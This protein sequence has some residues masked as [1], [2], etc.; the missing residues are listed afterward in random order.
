MADLMPGWRTVK[1]GDVVRLS[2]Q[3]SADPLT[4]GIERYVGLEHIEP[5]ELRVRTW[6]NVG[7]GTTFTSRF[8]PGQVLFGKR[9]AYQRKVAVAEFEGVCS[10]DIYVLE[11]VNPELL[12]P[13]LLP[14]ICQT[15]AFFEH[16][17]GTS[18]GSLSPRTNWGSLADFGFALPPLDEQQA[19][20]RELA[21]IEAA[22]ADAID[23]VDAGKQFVEVLTWNLTT[24]KSVGGPRK[25]APDWTYAR[26]PGVETLPESWTVTRLTE[27]ARLESGHTP[28][29]SKP[30]YWNGGIP[31]ISLADIKRL[32]NPEI[33]ETENEISHLGTENSSARL[34]PTGTVVFSRTAMIGYISVMSRPMATSQDFANFV[35]GDRLNHRFLFHLFYGMKEFWEYVAVGSSNVKTIY[36]PFFQKMQIALPPISVQDELVEQLDDVRSKVEAL[37]LRAGEHERMLAA[38]REHRLGGGRK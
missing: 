4:D 1:F 14:F 26:P 25:Q 27:V 20:V 10:G 12:L 5:G 18:A 13:E 28:S 30:E 22:R 38:L 15:D 7:D 6:G 23:A 34:L 16:A 8:R 37:R 24:G 17:V 31:W 9:R 32:G 36:M 2:K 21:A 3:R 35:C 11:V 29:R 33:G 19:L